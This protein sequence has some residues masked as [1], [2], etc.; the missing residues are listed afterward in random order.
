MLKS[1]VIRTYN[2]SICLCERPK[3]LISMI[4]G[5]LDVSLAPQTIYFHRWRD[6]NPQNNSRKTQI[7]F[8]NM[9]FVNLE[10]WISML[11]SMDVYDL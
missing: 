3:L 4:S 7:I 6:Q 8:E 9:I 5:I 10:I 1:S 2:F 11:Y